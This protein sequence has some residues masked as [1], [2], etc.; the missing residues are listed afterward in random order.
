[1]SVET[2]KSWHS[3]I[4]MKISS[5]LRNK[6]QKSILLRCTCTK[7]MIEM[8]DKPRGDVCLASMS[9]CYCWLLFGQVRAT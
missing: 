3:I 2:G 5:K 9:D 1:M 4:I 8:S 7:F 6:V